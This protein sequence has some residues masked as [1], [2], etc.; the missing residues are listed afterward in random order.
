MTDAYL[1]RSLEPVIEKASSQFPVV[2]L[3]S[4]RLSG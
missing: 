4:A 1:T 2:I 3:V